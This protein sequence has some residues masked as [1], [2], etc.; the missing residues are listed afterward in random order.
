MGVTAGDMPNARKRRP[1]QSM[2]EIRQVSPS[3]D[4]DGFTAAWPNRDTVVAIPA[5]SCS[6]RLVP[7]RLVREVGA[8][9][10]PSAF[11]AFRWGCH[12]HPLPTRSRLSAGTVLPRSQKPLE[13]PSGARKRRTGSCPVPGTERGH[14]GERRSASAGLRRDDSAGNGG[15][16]PRQARP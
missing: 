14:L 2:L 12:K 3:E 6:A 11:R 1:P 9:E 16:R 15:Q 8:A 5:P 10:P 13:P 7:A 4:R